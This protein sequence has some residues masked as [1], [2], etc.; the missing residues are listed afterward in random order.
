MRLVLQLQRTL[1]NLSVI[2]WTV[3]LGLSRPGCSTIADSLSRSHIKRKRPWWPSSPGNIQRNVWLASNSSSLYKQVHYYYFKPFCNLDGI[4][5][6]ATLKE[7]ERPK[8]PRKN[9]KD[10]VMTLSSQFC[11][12]NFVPEK[13]L[14]RSC[15]YLQLGKLSNNI[16]IHPRYIKM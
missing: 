9:Y 13:T 7:N 8:S 11:T 5:E 2:S 3:S 1:A 12:M 14:P 4:W 6:G 10:L 16:K 15:H